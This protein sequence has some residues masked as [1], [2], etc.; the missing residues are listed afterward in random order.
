MNSLLTS[1]VLAAL[2]SAAPAYAV[3]EQPRDHR[4]TVSTAGL[5]LA[6]TK[7]QHRLGLRILHAASSLCETPSAADPLGW[8]TYIRCRDEAVARTDAQRRAAVA[9][10]AA[11][12]DRTIAS[13]R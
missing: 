5:D 3:A 12:T 2:L 7:G 13:A 1:A 11:Q 4:T 9:S 6:S 10:A 8:K